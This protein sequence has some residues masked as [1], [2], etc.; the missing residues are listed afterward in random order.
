[1]NNH[2]TKKCSRC[3]QTLPLSLFY[4][5]SGDAYRPECKRCSE[6]DPKRTTT[7]LRHSFER[8]YREQH[9]HEPQR[10]SEVV[11]MDDLFTRFPTCNQCLRPFGTG[12]RAPSV[13][14]VTPVSDPLSTHTLGNLQL[15]CYRCQIRK[16]TLSQ[17]DAAMRLL[18]EE[19]GVRRCTAI[20]DFQGCGG[21]FP[22][23]MFRKHGKR[24]DGSQKY[25]NLCKSCRREYNK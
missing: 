3:G 13:D 4:K 17:E 15:V 2:T 7:T 19:A 5:W 9:G 16:H 10:L 21:V 24:G 6:N 25:L 20:G 8:R 11:S 22:L 1:M 23:S 12:D 18:E 14:H